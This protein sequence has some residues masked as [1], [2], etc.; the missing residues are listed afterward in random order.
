MENPCAAV[1]IICALFC[2]TLKQISRALQKMV[3]KYNYFTLGYLTHPSFLFRV[4][5]GRQRPKQML[6]LL[7]KLPKLS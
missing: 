3:L 4:H 1:I 5:I 2:V 6:F 7:R